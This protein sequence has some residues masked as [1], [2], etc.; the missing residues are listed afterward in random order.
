MP[1]FATDF[2][3]DAAAVAGEWLAA[4]KSLRRASPHTFEAYGRDIGQFACFL[5]DH[6]G[7]P[8]TCNDLSRLQASDF[9]AFLPSRRMG[10]AGSRSARG[11]SR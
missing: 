10:G 7:S 4:L 11:R 1:G 2:A 6:L 9:R 8:A 3:P 5:E